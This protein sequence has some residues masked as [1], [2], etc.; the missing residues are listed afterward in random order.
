MMGA[1]FNFFSLSSCHSFLRESQ[2]MAHPSSTPTSTV[3][4]P[5]AVPVNTFPARGEA[6][7]FFPLFSFVSDLLP[8][9]IFRML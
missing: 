7:S 6:G 1:S 9:V 8:L 4:F 2:E 3:L 5:G